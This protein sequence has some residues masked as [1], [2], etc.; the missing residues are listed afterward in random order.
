MAERRISAFVVQE[1]PGRL[2]LKIPEKRGDQAYFARLAAQLGEDRHIGQVRGNARTGS[3]LI[4]HP[5]AIVAADLIARSERLGLVF[6]AQRLVP[7]R[8]SLFEY[9]S[10]G[11]KVCDRRL[12]SVSRGF[13]DLPSAILL[14]LLILAL[15]QA[16][17][18][19]ILVPAFSLLWY[20]S[21]LVAPDKVKEPS[22]AA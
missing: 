22:R 20:A 14:G 19:D 13:I 5:P 10:A 18:G 4:L 2:R 6:P 9:V 17:R 3:L 8:Q 21:G 12:A 11:V 16:A 15:R 7:V 1:L